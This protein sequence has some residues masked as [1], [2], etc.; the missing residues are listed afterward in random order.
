MEFVLEAWLVYCFSSI[1]HHGSKLIFHVFVLKMKIIAAGPLT[2]L[3]PPTH[4]LPFCFLSTQSET[5]PCF[6]LSGH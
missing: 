3:Q 5:N 6:I 2:H 1:E 4:Q